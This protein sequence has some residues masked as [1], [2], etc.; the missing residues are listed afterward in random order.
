MAA[1]EEEPPQLGPAEALA[2][3]GE[4]LGLPGLPRL[5]QL[6]AE[7][8]LPRGAPLGRDV[9]PGLLELA[10]VATLE[11]IARSALRE[12]AARARSSADRS[13]VLEALASWETRGARG[14][15]AVVTRGIVRARSAPDA[16]GSAA[17]WVSLC[18]VA[19]DAPERAP[20][21]FTPE[22]RLRFDE[23]IRRSPATVRMARARALVGRRNEEAGQLAEP[24][25]RA[26]G[27]EAPAAEVLLLSGRTRKALEVLR[28]LPPPAEGPEAARREALVLTAELRLLREPRPAA[29][30]PR[31]RRRHR[32]AVR[33]RP[34]PAAPAPELRRAAEELLGR[35]PAALARPL[36]DADAQR[37]RV[38]GI[39]TGV[40]FGLFQAALA[41]VPPLVAAEPLATTGAEELLQDAFRRYRDGGGEAW[42]DAAARWDRIASLYRDPTTRRRATYWAARARLKAGDG[43]TARPLLA[44][45]LAGTSADLP[46]RWAARALGVPLPPSPPPVENDP[47]PDVPPADRPGPPSRELLAGGLPT[48]AEDA[49]EEE[50]SLDALF[51]S[52]LAAARGDYRRSVW[53][54]KARY[55][56]LGTPEEGAVP[57]HV[58][59][60]YYPLAHRDVVA[61]NAAAFDV[62]EPLL[63]GLIRQESLFHPVVRSGAGAVGLMQV[64]PGTARILARRER[65]GAR[66]DLEDPEVNVRLGTAYL[67]DML[68]RFGGDT[69]AALAAYNAG[70]GR[71]E[72]WKRDGAELASDEF[73]EAIP[74]R[75]TREYVSRVLF[76]EGAYAA[77]DA[78][79]LPAAGATRP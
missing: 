22:E 54:L 27:F 70:P 62:P 50:G 71:V 39:R 32:A 68:R 46:A 9:L 19:P 75:E 42:R 28:R 35:V 59:R 61:R 36:P 30:A 7:E 25:L 60:A 40:R 2:V 31:S 55:P 38:D 65:R 8:R 58:R 13:A 74:L 34:S 10:R 73:L 17:E 64:M 1:L 52:R 51:A 41:L 56:E 4:A 14:P 33:A 57:L 43:A 37:L 21:L 78:A 63:L 18:A 49:A 77:L 26:P 44:S 67:A 76:Y 69:I 48:L 23:A 79:R 20:D 15:R 24:L 47:D 45:L 6:R 11:P 53:L 29:R 12:A 5:L 72:R 16:A 3:P 66:P